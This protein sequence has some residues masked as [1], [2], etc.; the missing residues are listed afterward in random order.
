MRIKEAT[1]LIITFMIMSCGKIST[2]ATVVINKTT[3]NGVAGTAQFKKENNQLGVVV[4]I[5]GKPN[6]TN[7]VH[8]HQNGDCGNEGKNAGGHWNPTS[9]DHGTWGAGQH[10]SGDIGNITTNE[11][12]RGSIVVVDKNNRWTIG[13]SS[14]TNIIGRSIIIHVG[15]DD[16]TSQPT[17]NAG[18]RAG[19][20]TIAKER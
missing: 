4:K 15:S 5:Q 13:G 11:N 9:E 20:G 10:H 6:T 19:C 14:N 17:G 7:A 12:G 16:G 1:A 18:A 2:G 3:E 8:I